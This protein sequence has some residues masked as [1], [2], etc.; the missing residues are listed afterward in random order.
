[1]LEYTT[2]PTSDNQTTVI[3]IPAFNEADV[4]ADV[5]GEIQRRL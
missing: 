5:L 4:I 1:M 3:L 2:M